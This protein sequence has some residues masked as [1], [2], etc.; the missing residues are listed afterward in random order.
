[1]WKTEQ[2]LQT[3][4]TAISQNFLNCGYQMILL[5]STFQM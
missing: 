1:M 5:I 4:P 2:K 3:V